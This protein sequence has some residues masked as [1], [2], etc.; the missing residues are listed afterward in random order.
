[1]S[2]LLIAVIDDDEPFRMALVDSV[3][4][5]GY[6]ARGFASAE[7]FI[8]WEADASC[9]C[10]I[11]DV[12]MPGMSGL[13]LALL[14]TRRS[15]GVPVVMVT[16]RSDLGLDAR[17]SANGAICLLRKPFTTNALIDCLEKA[18]NA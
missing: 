3:G 17:A 8:A 10:V 14:L 1:V 11:T 13:D 16:A 15:R 9:D 6:G 12:H 7:E 4:S 18:L 2:E 5:L